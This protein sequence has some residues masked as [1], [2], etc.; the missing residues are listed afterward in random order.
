MI[1]ELAIAGLMA[2]PV[3][4]SA[5]GVVFPEGKACVAWKTR[6]T[7]FLVKKVE[8]VGI[9]CSVNIRIDSK[10]VGKQVTV[11]IP[12]AAF[13][14]GEK[15]RDRKVLEILK[16]DVSPALVFTSRIYTPDEWSV[17]RSGK[18][19]AIEGALAVGGESFPIV[20]PFSLSTE[21]P[22]IASGVLV[23]TFTRFKINPPKVAGGIVAS[24]QDYLEL[25]YRIP[26]AAVAQ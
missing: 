17:V 18:A 23:T 21:T 25:H 15:M 12:I 22:L 24:V 7:M 4:A 19:I 16:S 26:M 11:E 13:D 6:K 20:V 9:N 3:A 14:S 1:K 2:V 10:G 5:S 8:P